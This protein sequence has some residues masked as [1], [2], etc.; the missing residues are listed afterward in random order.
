[1]FPFVALGN[2]SPAKSPERKKKDVKEDKDDDDDADDD[3]DYCPPDHDDDEEVMGAGS[4][5]K[6]AR[7]IIE[8]DS[9]DSDRENE[10]D[11]SQVEAKA[12]KG[13][14]NKLTG[15]SSLES[16]IVKKK[17]KTDPPP[18][19]EEKLAT[20]IAET[21]G[22]KTNIK[23]KEKE[24]ELDDGATVWLHNKLEFLRP[25]NIR[26]GKKRKRDHPEYD[27]GTLFVP[28]SYLNTLTPVSIAYFFV[29]S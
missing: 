25:E 28:D 17:Q 19:F 7:I 20:R 26:D 13:K 9:E 14:K 18:S 16:P 8:S 2:T 4:K 15:Q 22:T 29:S 24:P 1:M 6:R 27:C 11:N 5:R 23:T 21:A 12:A 10:S 3:D